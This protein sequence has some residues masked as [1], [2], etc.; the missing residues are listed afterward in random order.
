[1]NFYNFAEKNMK[2]YF[3]VLLIVIITCIVGGGLYI[4]PY[5]S[6]AEKLHG[7]KVNSHRDD[8]IRIAYIGDS[9]AEGHKSVNCIIDSIV[10]SVTKRPVIVRTAGISGLTTKNVY[11]SIFRNDSI[12]NVI[13]WGPNYC[14]VV[15]GINDS[16]RKMGRGYYKDNMELIIETLLEYD[17]VPIILEIPSYDIRF[18]F[19]RRNRPIKLQY[20]VSMIITWS[21][22]D[23]INDYRNAYF[24]LIKEKGWEK[25][26]ITILSDNWN[27]EGYMDQRGLY[28]EGLMHLNEKGYMVLDS[29]IAE[30]VI[31][32]LDYTNHRESLNSTDR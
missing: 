1:M 7:L 11:Y 27:P 15:A 25:K 16:D 21:K 26:V 31:N 28:D 20:L 4:K 30:K 2:R 29:C 18:S 3:I 8:T 5:F 19:K 17:I 32:H 9:W 14:F 22:M 24:E 12:R 6:S 10:S 23:C 13:E